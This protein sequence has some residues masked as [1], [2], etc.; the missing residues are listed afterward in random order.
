MRILTVMILALVL[1]T[2]CQSSSVSEFSFDLIN[3]D[4][5]LKPFG[6]PDGW[7]VVKVQHSLEMVDKQDVTSK[8]LKYKEVPKRVMITFGKKAD[9]NEVDLKQIMD[10]EAQKNSSIRTLYEITETKGFGYLQIY[11]APD[12]PNVDIKTIINNDLKEIVINGHQIYRVVNEK[13]IINYVWLSK[14]KALVFDLTLSEE[15]SK[16]EQIEVLEV[17]S[18]RL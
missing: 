2:G 13:Q 7:D 5:G 4:F 8:Q 3:P 1:L 15:F 11:K 18:N 10:H 16:D 12:S 17:L 9:K 14:D 6:I